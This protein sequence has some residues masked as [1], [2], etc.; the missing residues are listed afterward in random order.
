[1]TKIT[2][3]IDRWKTSAM[4]MRARR[5]AAD[6]QR[7]QQEAEADRALAVRLADVM[8]AFKALHAREAAAKEQAERLAEAGKECADALEEFAQA[9]WGFDERLSRQLK[10]DM[11]PVVEFRA[12]LATY[13]EKHD[14]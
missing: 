11:Q 8:P 7:A 10:R 6:G 9:Q 3:L 14:G 5:Y 1:M 12:A 4:G 13:R 2:D